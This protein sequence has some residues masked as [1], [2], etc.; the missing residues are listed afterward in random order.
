MSTKAKAIGVIPA[1]WASTRFEG[2]V[3]AKLKGK[4]LIQH[5]WDRARRSKTLDSLLIACDDDRVF[6]AAKGFGAKAIM[7]SK[8][9]TS[10]TDRIAEAVGPLP[11]KVVVNLQA[12][13]PL[14]DPKMIDH[15]VQTILDDKACLMA[16]VVK[17]IEDKADLEN[18]NVVKVTIDQNR[19]ALYFSRSVIPFNRDKMKFED[20][21]YYK[22]LGLYA[23]RKEFLLKFKDLPKSHLELVEKLEQLR[24]LEAGY[25]IKTIETDKE[26]IGVD[27][28]EDLQRV[29]KLLG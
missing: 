14:V 7:T 28:P 1:R 3:L 27:T 13:E 12:D 2:K 6:K 19:N 25:K 16:T 9:H 29:E 18:P 21:N 11:V 4:Y 15:L 22:H 17:P 26:T 23:Y 10:G 8:K 20:I 5:V 24:V